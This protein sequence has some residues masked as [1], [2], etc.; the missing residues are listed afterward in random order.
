MAEGAG[1]IKKPARQRGAFRK[2]LTNVVQWEWQERRGQSSFKWKEVRPMGVL[3][4]IALLT[5]VLAA[6]QLGFNLKK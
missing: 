1:D 6:I 4:T 3:E 2:L 5:L